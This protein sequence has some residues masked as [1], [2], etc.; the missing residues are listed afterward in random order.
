[1]INGTWIENCVGITGVAHGISE[2]TT[3]PKLVARRPPNVRDAARVTII[4]VGACVV[5][6]EPAASDRIIEV[7]DFS[8]ALA[9]FPECVVRS[10]LRGNHRPRSSRALFGEDLNHSCQRVWS[11]DR[12]LRPTYDLDP[13]DIV[14]RNV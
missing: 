6:V 10:A 3:D 4:I 11:V 5:G 12:A 13:V 14:R 7:V 9:P 8:A 1:M 2:Q